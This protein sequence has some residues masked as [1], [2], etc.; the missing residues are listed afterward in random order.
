MLTEERG[1]ASTNTA[2]CC[3][4]LRLLHVLPPVGQINI[5]SVQGFCCQ[6]SKLC[7]HPFQRPSGPLFTCICFV[8]CV[9]ADGFAPQRSVCRE[10]RLNTN[11][12]AQSA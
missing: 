5:H 3:R 9:P 10:A 12:I 6:G 8:Q 11:N 1:Y 2:E 7:S 4:T